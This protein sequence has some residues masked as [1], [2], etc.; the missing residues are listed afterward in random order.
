MPKAQGSAT[1]FT[2]NYQEVP[3][4]L[5]LDLS[6]PEEPRQVRIPSRKVDEYA[7]HAYNKIRFAH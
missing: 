6:M 7:D 2:Q 5:H 3:A 1:S 4:N